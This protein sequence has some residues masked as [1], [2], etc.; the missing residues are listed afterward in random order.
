MPAKSGAQYRLMAGIAHGWKPKG[1]LKSAG[2]SPAVAEEFINKTSVSKRKLW[3]KG[4][5]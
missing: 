4:G 1:K 5:K 2:P 3:S